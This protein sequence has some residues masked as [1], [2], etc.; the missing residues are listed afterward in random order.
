MVFVESVLSLQ[1]WSLSLDCFKTCIQTAR[2]VLLLVQH[3]K[4]ILI[5]FMKTNTLTPKQYK[6]KSPKPVMVIQPSGGI[7]YY[8]NLK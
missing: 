2:A 5:M 6:T 1:Q 4:K 7:P 3:L 8:H